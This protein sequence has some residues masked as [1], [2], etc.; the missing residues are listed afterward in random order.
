MTRRRGEAQCS[1]PVEADWEGVR[2]KGTIYYLA[3]NEI[4]VRLEEPI[5]GKQD[6]CRHIPYFAMGL[7]WL[8]LAAW[9]DDGTMIITERGR[10]IARHLIQE[11]YEHR[12]KTPYWAP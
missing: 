8:H 2:L 12:D 1:I 5:K 4:A 11:I 6:H 9:N 10:D 3:P 7:T